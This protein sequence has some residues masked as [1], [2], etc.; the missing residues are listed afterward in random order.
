MPVE[1]RRGDWIQRVAIHVV[2]GNRKW[3]FCKEHPRLLTTKPPL[4]LEA[5]VF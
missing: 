2:A 3:A 4:Q 5:S 1:I